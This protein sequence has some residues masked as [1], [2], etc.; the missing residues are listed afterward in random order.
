MKNVKTL[1]IMLCFIIGCFC[2]APFIICAKNIDG[3]VFEDLNK[4]KILD[5]EEKGIGGVY[6]S[7]QQ[8]IVKTDSSGRYRIDSKEEDIIYVIKPIGYKFPLNEYNLPQ[9]YYIYN[10]KGSPKMWYEGIAPT[11]VVPEKVNFPLFKTDDAKDFEVVVFADTQT[12]NEVE[13]NYMKQDTIN[14]LVGSSA[15]FGMILGDIV[16]DDLSMF[17]KVNETVSKVGIPFYNV[18]GNHDLNHDAADNLY[19]YDTFKSKYGPNYYSYNYGEVHFIVLADIEWHGKTDTNKPYYIGNIDDRQLEWIKNDLRLVDSEKLIVFT[20]HIPPKTIISDADGDKI[21]NIAKL[22]DLIKDRKRVLM[23][24]GHNHTAE[25]YILDEKSGYP[26]RRPVDMIVCSAVCGAWYGGPKD[27]RGIPVAIQQD[28]SPNG[29]YIFKFSGTKYSFEFK[30]SSMSIDNQIRISEPQDFI[31]QTPEIAQ[32][33]IVANV[34]NAGEKCVV[35]CIIDN[36]SPQVMNYTIMEDPYVVNF[37]KVNKAEFRDW[38]APLK[39]NH[40]WTLPMP[41]DLTPGIHRIIVT[42]I[43][44]SG[45][46]VEAIKFF[47]LMSTKQ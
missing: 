3:I 21:V 28:G 14:E 10:P 37:I 36:G 13:I 15:K 11:G 9:F 41:A 19:A 33:Q 17:D 5:P 25:Q 26:G 29:Y 6:V 20:M 7:N 43:L 24:A 30:P 1:Y 46:K 4:N 27:E 34:F 39:S 45:R 31:L 2:S 18:P 35:K 32:A 23:L 16:F 42:T 40:I 47:K 12:L 22:Y 38:V 8:N 44:D